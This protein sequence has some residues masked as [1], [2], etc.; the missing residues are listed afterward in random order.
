MQALNSSRSFFSSCGV[1]AAQLV[2]GLTLVFSGNGCA[3]SSRAANAHAARGVFVVPVENVTID[4]PHSTAATTA[5]TGPKIRF[6][7]FEKSV[8]KN[9]EQK[10]EEETTI[11]FQEAAAHEN[12]CLSDAV[13]SALQAAS[14]RDGAQVRALNSI[15]DDLVQDLC[16]LSEEL[17]WVNLEEGW[18]DSGSLRNFQWLSCERKQHIEQAF[19]LRTMELHDAH[20]FAL[21]VKASQEAG[22]MEK[23]TLEKNS[24]KAKALLARP[25]SAANKTLAA[26]DLPEAIGDDAKKEYVQRIQSIS[27]RTKK[28]ATMTCSTF[29]GLESELGGA[30]PCKTQV[31]L[32]YASRAYFGDGI[33]R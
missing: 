6:D 4:R 16:W 30:E 3:S 11:G 19:L 14:T 1:R 24:A 12:E 32:Y 10:P 27:D 26:A 8:A 25:S 9:C 20:G 2:F 5:A 33:D 15:H 28:I 31:A 21:H 7:A 13:T 23:T 22:K 18:R 17:V 29:V